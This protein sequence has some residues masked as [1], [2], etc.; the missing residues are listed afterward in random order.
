[1]PDTREPS[2]AF[3]PDL[4]RTLGYLPAI[5]IMIGVTV[6]SGI[7]ATPSGIAR[8][9]PDPTWIMALWGLGGL[10]SFFGA[11]TFSELICMY[12]SSGGLY[13]FL[14]RGFGERIA[15]IFGWT[16]MLVTKPF[17]AAG[18]AIVSAS[19]FNQLFGTEWHLPTMVCVELV[20]L[21]A[22]NTLGMRLGA[23][24]GVVVTAFKVAALMGIVGCAV[25]LPGGSAGNFAADPSA[26]LSVGAVIAV[27]S[28]V[29]WTYDGWSDVGSVAGEVR[30]PQRRLPRIYLVGTIILVALYLVVN[31]AYLYVL[32]IREIAASKAVAGDVMRQLIGDKGGRLVTA[33]VLVSTVG[34]THASIITGARV[35]FAQARDGLLFRFLSR[36]SPRFQ[37]P[38]VSLWSQCVLSCT[39]VLFLGSFQKLADGFVF[40][41]WIFYGL[42]GAAV[43]ILRR[44]APDAVRTFRVPGYPLVPC[45]FIAAAMVMTVLTV[46]SDRGNTFV[47][48]LPWLGVLAAGWPAFDLWKWVVRKRAKREAGRGPGQVSG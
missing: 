7:F 42:G 10:L 20:V 11:L 40:T 31:A 28:S 33:A 24:V 36:V 25:V 2:A 44:T 15:F 1:M 8:A 3:S 18:I 12:P 17:A 4:P 38:A 6:G 14:R 29:L 30:D 32:P 46:W 23:G 13:N 39:A 19:Y 26:R 41:M 34:A 47:N 27:M 35:T 37:V 45:L 43:I 9:L 22:I 5:G 48:T 16:Y 21:T